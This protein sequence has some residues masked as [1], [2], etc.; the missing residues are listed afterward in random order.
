MRSLSVEGF[1]SAVGLPEQWFRWLLFEVFPFGVLRPSWEQHE[2]ETW[3]LNQALGIDLW[4]ARMGT[5][6]KLQH[7]NFSA[8]G[9]SVAHLHES[10]VY[11]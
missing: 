1:C 8:T 2:T 6:L 5:E 11:F 3:E 7:I 10:L 4:I 9:T